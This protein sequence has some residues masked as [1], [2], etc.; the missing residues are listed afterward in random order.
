MRFYS[1]SCP[2]GLKGIGITR[3]GIEGMLRTDSLEDLKDQS[4]VILANR[5]TEDISDVRD[6]VFSRDLFNVD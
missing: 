1:T 2:Q 4:D 6:K 3:D 5:L